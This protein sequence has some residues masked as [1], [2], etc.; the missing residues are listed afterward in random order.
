MNS[1]FKIT[2]QNVNIAAK[3]INDLD[4]FFVTFRINENIK[5]N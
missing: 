5:Y 4:I 1:I 2:T 3:I